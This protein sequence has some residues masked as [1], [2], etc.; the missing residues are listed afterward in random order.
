MF[1]QVSKKIIAIV[2]L[3]TFL[4]TNSAWSFPVASPVVSNITIAPSE[5]LID[6]ITI[7]PQFGRIEERHIGDSD[8]T[9]AIIQDAHCN[10]E[11][12][13]NESEIIKTL[14][15]EHGFEAIYLE[16]A[17]GQVDTSIFTA[18][19][20]KEVKEKVFKEALKKGEIN[21]AD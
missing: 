21:G 13:L 12:Q 2:A 14:V 17:V 18:Y 10:Y 8:V 20:H 19:P 9:V 7:D 6:T 11:A 1:N 3:V 4:S 15:E 16:G 5:H